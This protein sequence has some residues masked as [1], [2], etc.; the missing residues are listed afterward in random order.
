MPSEKRIL[1][2]REAEV[3]K[4]EFSGNVVNNRS[5][6]VER[7]TPLAL[8]FTCEM[9]TSKSVPLSGPVPSPT[10]HVFGFPWAG[11]LNGCF[12]QGKQGLHFL[13]FFFRSYYNT[14]H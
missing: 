8:P 12:P 11:S 10:L 4:G 5:T 9:T 13:F 6:G 1:A 7:N 14:Q 2:G 3:D